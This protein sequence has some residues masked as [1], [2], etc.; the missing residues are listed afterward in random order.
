MSKHAACDTKCYHML[1]TNIQTQE[2][3]LSRSSCIY[4]Q[5]YYCFPSIAR[6][7]QLYILY[8]IYMDLIKIFNVNVGNAL[9][10]YGEC[11]TCKVYEY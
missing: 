5:R 2:T 10:Y 6:L 8:P 11:L 3:S 7:K 1:C 4:V 9:Y